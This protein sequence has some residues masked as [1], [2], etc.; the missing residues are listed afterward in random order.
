MEPLLLQVLGAEMRLQWHMDV[1]PWPI[2]LD[3]PQL[4]CTLVNL[5][6]NARD[7]CLERGNVTVRTTNT[8]LTAAFPDEAGL[9]PGDYV[10]VH[11]SDDGHGMSADELARVFEP[12]FTTKPA[13]RGAGLGLPMAHG[14]VGQSGGYLWLEST[15]DQGTTVSMLF[16]RSAEAIADEPPI[17]MPTVQRA[18]GQRL[19][20]VDDE[21]NLRLLMR[22][23]L[24]ERGFEV[25]DVVDANSALDR[26]RHHGP[27]D[28]V[29]T[30]IGLPGGF[31]GRQ[32]ARAMRMIQPEQ[33]ILF[34]TGYTHHTLEPQLLEAPGTGLLLKPF[35]LET[36]A[37]QALLMLTE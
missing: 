2:C 36:L 17:R 21:N 11:V 18:S 5:C 26:F 8:R 20:L 13:G 27:F 37:D 12:F 9:P 24:R 35:P 28:L 22:E 4:E 19:L 33:K 6:A 7:A 30:D 31:S 14:F 3:I 16:P 32:V 15:P 23:Y 29:I 25:C 10:A 34:I 1:A